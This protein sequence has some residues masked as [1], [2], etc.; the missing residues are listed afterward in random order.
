MPQGAP[1]SVTVRG[2]LSRSAEVFRESYCRHGVTGK[3]VAGPAPIS[4]ASGVR[5]LAEVIDYVAGGC[6]LMMG[7]FVELGVRSP[8]AQAVNVA[9]RNSTADRIEKSLFM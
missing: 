1:V 6:Q 8:A 2:V 9:D 5:P 3:N 7:G 4:P